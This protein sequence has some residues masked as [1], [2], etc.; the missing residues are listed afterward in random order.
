M[1]EFSISV[2]KIS[3]LVLVCHSFFPW[4]QLLYELFTFCITLLS[5]LEQQKRELSWGLTQANE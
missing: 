1:N 5:L 4:G 3:F 2:R